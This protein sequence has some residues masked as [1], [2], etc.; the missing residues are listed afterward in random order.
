MSCEVKR[1]PH[2]VFIDLTGE[3]QKENCRIKKCRQPFSTR[4]VSG[5]MALL[6]TI[7]H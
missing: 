4:N 7:K 5:A 1:E 6:D 3:R 2:D